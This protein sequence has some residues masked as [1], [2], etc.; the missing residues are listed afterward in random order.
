MY[1]VK[2]NNILL[3]MYQILTSSYKLSKKLYH[4]TMHQ[5]IKDAFITVVLSIL[6][7]TKM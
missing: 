2:F 4:S 1:I 6:I 3:Y 5:M 7:N